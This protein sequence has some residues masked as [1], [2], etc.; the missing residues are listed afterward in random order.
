MW[1]NIKES[2]I[3]FQTKTSPI[4]FSTTRNI[5]DKLINTPSE[6][7]II[8]DDIRI[9]EYKIKSLLELIKKINLL[10]DACILFCEQVHSN[11]VVFVPKNVS[12][13]KIKVG[14]IEYRYK[15]YSSTDGIISD[16]NN[17][18]IFIFTADCVPFFIYDEYKKYIGLIHIG[19]KGLETDILKN[20][21]NMLILN[22]GLCKR[23]RFV[24][25]PHICENCYIINGE[26]YSLV[27]RIKKDL[28]EFNIKDEQVIV[29]PYCTSCHNEMFYSYR[30]NNKT[31]F[32][33]ISAITYL[34]LPFNLP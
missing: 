12:F 17:A 21:L 27:K 25:G 30:K 13:D 1:Y 33:I 5:I 28:K 26:N 29:S 3:L 23:L 4:I 14:N 18:I 34:P 31:E 10:Q 11:K 32:R 8:N 24:I 16:I 20:A 15:F 2:F 6:N 22:K 9:S 7:T 19:R